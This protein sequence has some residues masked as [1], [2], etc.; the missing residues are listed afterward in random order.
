MRPSLASSAASHGSQRSLWARAAA[1]WP[2]S[3]SAANFVLVR[4]PARPGRNARTADAANAWLLERGLV[5]REMGAYDLSDCL[6][7]GLGLEDDMRALVAAL[8]EFMS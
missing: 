1:T 8:A 2:V 6:R 5:T 4:F 7:I 3:P